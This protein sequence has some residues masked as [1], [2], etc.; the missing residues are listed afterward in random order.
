MSDNQSQVSMDRA[1]NAARAMLK[2][3]EV[4][5]KQEAVQLQGVPKEDRLACLV[6]VRWCQGRKFEG[7][8]NAK[9]RAK[10][11]FFEA[12]R[13]FKAIYEPEVEQPDPKQLELPRS[14][15]Q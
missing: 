1:I 2:G 6:F 7:G 5:T 11:T 4:L 12:A 13:I 10:A 8:I 15:A 14:G 3:K 9:L